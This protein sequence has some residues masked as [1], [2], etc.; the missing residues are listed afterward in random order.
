MGQGIGKA[1]PSDELVRWPL[2]D[3]D[4]WEVADSLVSGP[5]SLDSSY[6]EVNKPR[7]TGVTIDR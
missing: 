2:W 4:P 7:E 6:T 5:F 1:I 3:G